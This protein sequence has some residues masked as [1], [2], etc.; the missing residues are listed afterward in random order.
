MLSVMVSYKNMASTLIDSEI[1]SSAEWCRRE[2]EYNS[3]GHGQVYVTLEET[4]Q[5]FLGLC[6]CLCVLS[7]E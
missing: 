7:V 1:Y 6:S 3:H 2:E 4:I 5:K